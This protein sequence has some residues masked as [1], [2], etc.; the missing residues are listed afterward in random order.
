MGL[1]QFSEPELITFFAV[2][3]RYT[4]MI[5]VLPIFGNKLIPAPIKVL[6]GLTFTFILFPTLVTQGLVDIS[7]A[8]IWGKKASSLAEVVCLEAGFGLA[9]GF[10]AKLFFEAI[11]IGANIAGTFMGF[12]SASMYDP[13]SESQSMVVA[14]LQSTLA[15]LIF[16]VID[17]H[18][19]ML[20]AAL[21]SYRFVGMGQVKLGGAF[22]E[23]LISLS[24]EMIRIGLQIAAPM[25][26]SLFAIHIVYAIMAKAVPQLNILILS[27]SVSALVGLIVLWIS[28]P[29]FHAMTVNVFGRVE[30]EMGM[31]MV[32]LRSP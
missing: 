7:Q 16:L 27:F 18:H 17:G 25:A 11:N 9:L 2:L 4:V 15:M 20:R 22:A 24:G 26:I 13:H 28:L 10:T 30:H 3:V 12:A 32:A 8:A 19:T 31:M 6:L 29:E 1:F 5:A 21:E 23:R 14:R